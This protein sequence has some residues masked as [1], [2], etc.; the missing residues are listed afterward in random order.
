[1]RCRACNANLSDAESTNFDPV[2]GEYVDICFECL[3]ID[4]YSEDCDEDEDPEDF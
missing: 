4:D 3:G 2:L 1:M